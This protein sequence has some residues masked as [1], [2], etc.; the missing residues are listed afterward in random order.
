MVTQLDRMASPEYFWQGEEKKKKKTQNTS[1]FNKNTL[2]EKQIK[3][4]ENKPLK[5]SLNPLL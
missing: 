3:K 2:I 1:S 4:K 5:H